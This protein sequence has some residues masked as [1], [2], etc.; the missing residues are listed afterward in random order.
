MGGPTRL[1]EVFAL[2]DDAG[3]YDLAPLYDFVY[4]H[5]EDYERQATVVREAGRDGAVLEFACGTGALAQRLVDDR[6]YV[7]VD[8]SPAML[9]VARRSVDA[10]FVLG[11]VRRVAFGRRFEVVAMLGRAATHFD[12]GD[13]ASAA[14]VAR[15]H[16]RD[17]GAFVLDAHDR[18]V[19]ED[20]HTSEDRFE[21]DRW[22]VTYRGVS[23][24]TGGGWCEH[25]YAYDVTDTE[26]GESRTFS[27][28]YDMRFW[29]RGELAELLRAAGFERVAVES[30]AVGVRAVASLA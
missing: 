12:R 24:T 30:A 9:E 19:L 6:C 10:P 14:T 8:A 2:A 11:D 7:G 23:R 27:G 25:E 21:S 26:T 3:F 4:R 15:E 22:T 17:G 28:R 20:G 16:L 13:L 1:S 5:R 18:A 29:G